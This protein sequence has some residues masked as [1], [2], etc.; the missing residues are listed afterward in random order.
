MQ[1]ILQLFGRAGRGGSIAQTHLFFYPRQKNMD[2]VVKAFGL[3]GENCSCKKLLQAVGSSERIQLGNLCCDRCV[4]DSIP[5]R[6]WFEKT[7]LVQT[8]S[9]RCVAVYDIR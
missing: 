7:S 6:L 4:G 8:G 3:E 5:L 1:F 9:K 2:S